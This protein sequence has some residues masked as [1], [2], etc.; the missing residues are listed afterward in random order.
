MKHRLQSLYGTIFLFCFKLMA[1]QDSIYDPLK[2]FSDI[3]IGEKVAV[4]KWLRLSSQDEIDS[5]LL[6][7]IK[8]QVVQH[9]DAVAHAVN[10]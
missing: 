8:P 1:A 4:T 3:S 2:E 6:S 5:S 7:K 10:L 9:P